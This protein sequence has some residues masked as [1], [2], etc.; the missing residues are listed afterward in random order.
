[1]SKP[2]L[3]F[4]IGD[5][6]YVQRN[7]SY[8]VLHEDR[9]RP[10]KLTVV[11]IITVAE[12]PRGWNDRPTPGSETVKYVT[13]YSFSDWLPESCL[14]SSVEEFEERRADEI[15]ALKAKRAAEVHE[16]R[17]KAYR[18]AKRLVADFEAELFEAHAAQKDSAT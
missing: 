3:R 13:S 10:E 9:G 11:G 7:E 2:D 8:P 1:M 16:K 18:E 12:F 14:Y 6:V 4:K 15:A 17:V 5:R